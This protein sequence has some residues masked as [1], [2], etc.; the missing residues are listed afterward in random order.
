MEKQD[1]KDLLLGKALRY[2][3]NE[4]IE[5]WDLV[6]NIE[7]IVENN[8][9]YECYDLETMKKELFAYCKQIKKEEK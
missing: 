5:F 2:L 3:R 6:L 9:N 8:L 4:N 7:F 1:I